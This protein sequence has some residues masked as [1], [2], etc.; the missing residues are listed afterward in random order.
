MSNK[1]KFVVASNT[2]IACADY[3]TACTTATTGLTCTTGYV[4][5]KAS[6]ACVTCGGIKT[7]FCA[8]AGATYTTD[9]PVC[10]ANGLTAGTA[11]ASGDGGCNEGYQWVANTSTTTGSNCVVCA[12]NNC[13]TCTKGTVDGD[14]CSAC[15][16][17]YNLSGSGTSAACA[18]CTSS[19]SSCSSSACLAPSAQNPGVASKVYGALVSTAT[20]AAI[21]DATTIANMV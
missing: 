1:L 4:L 9:Q 10:T 3:A 6:T 7:A 17:G 13:K 8:S 20:C 16:N 5:N 21:T 18:L 12:A 11:C 15:F 14:T 2:C 19:T